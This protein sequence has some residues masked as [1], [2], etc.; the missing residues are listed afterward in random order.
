MYHPNVARSLVL[1]DPLTKEL[2]ANYWPT[3]AL[4]ITT[5]TVTNTPRVYY[6][7]GTT[8]TALYII[9]QSCQ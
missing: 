6:V 5:T 4:I 7:L 1:R 3:P 8:P 2:T 9:F